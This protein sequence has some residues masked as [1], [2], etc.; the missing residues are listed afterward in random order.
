MKVKREHL[1]A[2]VGSVGSGKS[3]LLSA[4]LGEMD[5]LKGRVNTNGSIAY[6]SQQAWIQNATLRD[7]ITFGKAFDQKMYDRVVFAC[8]LKPDIE[9]L[10]G[11]DQTEIGEKGIN[12]SGGQKQRVSLARAVYNNADI[13]FLD[14]PLSAVDSHVGKHIFD[15]VIGPNGILAKKSRILV[16]HGITYLPNTDF[17]YVLK[18]GEISESGAYKDLLEKK[19]A[20][21]EFL[22]QHLQE[23]NPDE[24]DLDEIKQ[25]L[26]S[27]LATGELLNK[28]ERAISRPRSDSASGDANSKKSLSRQNS[29]NSDDESTGLRHRK[30]SETSIKKQD[31]LK[32]KDKLIEQEKSETGS[33]S[34]FFLMNKPFYKFMV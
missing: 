33:V 13:Y 5:K 8:A 23:I 14:D 31:E 26:E 3:S 6:V 21:A 10:P 24:E 2:V 1:V 18:N 34:F 15:H 28:L 32:V 12:L 4:Y 29:N 7:N 17:I 25:Q 20:F 30:P 27:N 11:G 9:M 19:G 16:T 22:I